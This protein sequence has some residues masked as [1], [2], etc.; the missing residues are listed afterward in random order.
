M[1]KINS[2]RKGSNGKKWDISSVLSDQQWGFRSKRDTTLALLTVTY[3][4]FSSLDRGA[5]G[6]AI[7]FDLRKAFDSVPHRHLITSLMKLITWLQL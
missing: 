4:W 5:E 2:T 7:F 6:C 3:D 1:D